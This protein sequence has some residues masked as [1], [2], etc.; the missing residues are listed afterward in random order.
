[1]RKTLAFATFGTLLG[2]L[3]IAPYAGYSQVKKQG[4]KYL[5]RYKWTTGRKLNYDMKTVM[6]FGG[7]SQTNSAPYTMKVLSV[8]N[9]LAKISMTSSGQETTFSIDS[10]GRT[11][12][13]PMRDGQMP[14]L[15]KEAIAK[16]AT[17]KTNQ[18]VATPMGSMK[19]TTVWTFKGTK[20]VNGSTKAILTNTVTM[21]G[22]MSGK[23]TGSFLLDMSDA[24]LYRGTIKMDM[25]AKGP[26]AKQSMNIGMSIYIT[27]K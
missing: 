17:W 11:K 15:P 24:M 14:T 26:E 16:G 22:A 5:F 23:G 21:S 8:K 3:V 13:L 19:S 6:S 7:Q 12:D 18:D 4:S 1:M 27:R 25:K 10:L 9:G 2:L 20:V